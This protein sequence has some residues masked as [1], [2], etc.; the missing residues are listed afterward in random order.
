MIRLALLRHGHTAWNRASR[1]QGRTDIPLDPEAEAQLSALRL[2][3]DWARADIVASPLRRAQQTAVLVSGR[4]A[5]PVAALIEMNWGDWEG[6]KGALLRD[7]PEADYRPVE[8]WGWDHAPPGGESA[9][10]MRDRLLPWL[11]SL[12]RD[13]LAV[14]HIGVM[15]VILALA[16]GWQFQGPA[17][18]SIKRNRL[19]IVEID[20]GRMRHLPA[21]LRL[22][23]RK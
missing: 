4:V 5:R 20:S 17:P 1:I 2:P 6:Q 7:D 13:T 18:F 12:E 9:G 23:V 10:Q 21:P 16:T 11:G 3:E 19:F 15:R 8:N 22:E 14:S